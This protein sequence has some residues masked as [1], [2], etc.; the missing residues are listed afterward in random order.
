MRWKQ[1]EIVLVNA[2][3]AR[4]KNVGPL[5]IGCNFVDSPYIFHP[6]QSIYE[7]SHSSE[8]SEYYRISF[9]YLDSE[10]QLFK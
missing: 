4:H 2:R 9:G 10:I 7:K 1:G 5:F 8:Y 3:E 6:H